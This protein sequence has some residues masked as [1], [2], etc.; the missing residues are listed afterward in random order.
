MQS[1]QGSLVAQT[2]RIPHMPEGG[3]WIAR[4]GAEIGRPV[5]SAS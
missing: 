2:H 3:I 1:D 4:N 5:K